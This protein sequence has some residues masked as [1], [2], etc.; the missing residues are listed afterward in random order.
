[1]EKG[2]ILVTLNYA[3]DLAFSEF[4]PPASNAL[5][6]VSRTQFFCPTSLLKIEVDNTTP[7]GY[8]MPK[9]A[10]AMFSSSL[11]FRTRTPSVEW[12]RKVVS[13]YAEED[14]LLSGWLLGEDVIA[15][16]AAVVDTKYKNG[17]IILIGF[18]CQ[19]RAQSHGTYK[20]LLNSLL[21]PG[22]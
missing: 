7:I 17:H 21:Y 5:E 2:G 18:R 12:D 11:A 16:K 6:G 22:N 4:Q 13:N 1:V 19:F 10:A 15:R 20:F 3:C 8:G 14:V 9:E